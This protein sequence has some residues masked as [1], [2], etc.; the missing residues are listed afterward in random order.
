MYKD[1]LRR[2]TS[3]ILNLTAA[4]LNTDS[5]M[6]EKRSQFKLNSG[7]YFKEAFIEFD[8]DKQFGDYSN[9]NDNYEKIIFK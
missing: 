4:G 8:V 3:S 7:Q 2:N 1:L 5:Q 9:S 6:E